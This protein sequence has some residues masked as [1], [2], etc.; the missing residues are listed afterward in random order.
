MGHRVGDFP[1]GMSRRRGS[2]A[3]HSTSLQRKTEWVRLEDNE[4]SAGHEE[5][6]EP[7]GSW[8]REVSGACPPQA[9]CTQDGQGGPGPQDSQGR[10][11]R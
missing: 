8:A 3:G 6:S 11:S 2:R 4:E 1:L 5:P 7:W 9:K 10:T